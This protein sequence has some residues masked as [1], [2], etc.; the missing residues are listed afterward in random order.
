M[1]ILAT[2][3]LFL[4]AVPAA[5]A[6]L[7]APP[8]RSPLSQSHPLVGRIWLPAEGRFIDAAELARRMVAADFILLG[9]H[10]DNLDHHRLQT[11]ALEQVIA[12]GRRPPVA[13]EML[14]P[15]QEPG[16]RRHLAEHPGQVEGLDAAVDWTKSGWPEWSAYRPLFAAALAAGLEIRTANVP[17]ADVRA[18]ARQQALPDAKRAY[19]GL[20]QPL[21]AATSAA[22]AEEIRQ[23]HC[24]QLP[25]RMVPGMVEVQ[26]ARDTAMARAM[27]ADAP[28]GAVLIAGA[29]HV[30]SD[31]GVPAQIAHL[32]PDRPIFSL[33]FVEVVD[34]RTDPDSYGEPWGTDKPP[35]DAVWF[36]PR[37]SDE[38]PCAGFAEHMKKKKEREEKEKENK[39]N[40]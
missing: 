3:L 35:F 17:L 27:T 36:T 21:D 33:G 14:S 16:L 26:R 2:L 31:R 13:F 15:E 39:G 4:A 22:M 24:S 11:W 28:T 9:E 12:V 23:S 10:H 6:D 38:D 30:R 25:E 19:Y 20:D 8:W 32:A 7:P 5:A 40:G 34:D 37:A 18:L 29:G 1:R